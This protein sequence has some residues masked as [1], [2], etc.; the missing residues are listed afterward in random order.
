MSK[1]KLIGLVKFFRNESFLDSLIEGGFH[2][3]TPEKYRLDE[4]AGI[5]DLHES[6]MH[7]YRASRGDKPAVLKINGEELE[8]LTAVTT[9]MNKLK[10]MWLHCWFALDFPKNDEQLL[11]L[12]KDLQ[13]V[14]AEFGESFAFLPSAHLNEF[15]NRVASLQDGPFV[16]GRVSYSQDRED[17]SVG[18]KSV[19]YAYQREYRF[20]LGQCKHTSL[21]PLVLKYQNGF[22]D[23]LEKNPHIKISDKE[24]NATWFY[25]SKDECYCRPDS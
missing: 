7:A 24:S 12:T 21:E 4:S 2:C 16:R 13:R 3:N 14:R 8:G 22:R 11:A 1:P 6:C 20:G 18:Y 17:W 23:L 15:T 19:A 9:H 5:G 10:D 25:L